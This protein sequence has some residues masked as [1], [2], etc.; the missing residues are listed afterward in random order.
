[1]AKRVND[2]TEL[3]VEEPPSKQRKVDDAILPVTVPKT[4]NI[5]NRYLDQLNGHERDKRVYFD[6]GGDGSLHDYW[7][8]W[9]GDAKFQSR[10]SMS[11]TTIC[12]SFFAEFDADKII[13]NMMNGKNWHKN[14]KYF[15]KSPDAIKLEWSGNGNDARTEGTRMHAFIDDYYNGDRSLDDIKPEQ[16]EL[17]L[18][19]KF[20]LD[21]PELIPYRSEWFV[22]T[23]NQTRITGAIDMIFVNGPIMDTL[24]NNTE[25]Y[26]AN[27]PDTLHVNIYDWKRSKQIKKYNA[28][29]KGFAPLQRLHNA[30][31]YHYSIQLNLYKYILENYYHNVQWRGKTYKNIQVTYLYLSIFHPSHAAMQLHRCPDYQKEVKEIIEL[32]KISL[33]RLREGLPALYPFDK[34]QPPPIATTV[35]AVIEADFD[36]DKQ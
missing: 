33:Q 3:I 10:D 15:G 17:W 34:T 16:K 26:G 13:L 14:K 2:K 4:C 21:Y 23:D 11:V 36:Y 20:V 31:F 19:R 30:N 7:V 29:D 1:M 27:E 5:R 24:W 18:F 28:W 25:K 32:R 6:D 22:F 35:N 12:K 9:D 8:D